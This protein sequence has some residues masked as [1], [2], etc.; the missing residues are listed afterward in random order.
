MELSQHG[1]V[2]TV[3]ESGCFQAKVF[4]KRELFV[5]YDGAGTGG[6]CF[7]LSLG[8]LVDCL[9]IFSALGQ[10]AT[11]EIWYSSPNMRLLL[12]YVLSGNTLEPGADLLAW[13]NV[14]VIDL[15]GP[16][17][18]DLFNYCS[19]K[20]SLKTMLML[21]DQM[22]NRVEYM[23]QKGLVLFD[24]ILLKPNVVTFGAEQKEK[25]SPEPPQSI[26]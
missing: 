20:F 1:I 11:V 16:S 22:I 18:E 19:R 10:V 23:H 12:K 7:R 13:Y 25:N 21:A 2:L 24:G 15:L 17:L 6:S 5:E 26:C 9:N 4:L 8:L 3:E 14:M